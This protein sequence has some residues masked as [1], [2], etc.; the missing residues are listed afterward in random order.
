MLEAADA[1]KPGTPGTSPNRI[2]RTTGG[3]ARFPAREPVF[4]RGFIAILAAVVA[5]AAPQAF[6]QSRKS[7][8]PVLNKLSGPNRQAFSGVVTSLDMKLK[9]L[10]VERGEGKDVEIFPLKKETHVE[11]A[12]GNRLSLKA[13]KPGTNV[14]I[15]FN[16]K[17]GERKVT[18]VMVLGMEKKKSNEASHPAS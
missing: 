18:Q 10:N 17:A 16:E 1:T 4:R 13:L 8:V 6:A 3:F 15:Y 2:A 14:L 12:S 7:K 11:D 9:I 5:L